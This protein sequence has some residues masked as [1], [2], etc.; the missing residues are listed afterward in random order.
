M[1]KRSS[2]KNLLWAAAIA[3]CLLALFISLLIAAFSRYSGAK[4]RGGVHLDGSGA[5]SSV[6]AAPEGIDGGMDAALAGGDG[7]LHQLGESADAGQGYVE[8]LTFLVDSSLIGLRDSG[9]L[10]VNGQATTQVWGS[11]AGNLPV[12]TLSD[13]LIRY[14][15]DGSDLSP[16]NAALVVKPSRLVICVGSDALSQV[17]ETAFKSNYRALIDSL[18]RSSPDTLLIVCSLPSVVPGYNGA[19]ELSS[20]LV[21]NANDWIRDLCIETGAYYADCGAAVRDANGTLMAEYASANG[22]TLNA[23]GLSV[24]LNYLRT[25]SV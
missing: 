6:S 15:G 22:K 11:A 4:Q 24:I 3:L 17:D 13:C 19:D 16:A 8:S 9:I 2:L 14:P 25:H 23:A 21:G 18:R 7:S 12:A 20:Y 5:V 10:T 1:G